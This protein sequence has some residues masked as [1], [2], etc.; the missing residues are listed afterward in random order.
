MG[1]QGNPGLGQSGHRA[2]RSNRHT[3]E[4][5]GAVHTGKSFKLMSIDVHTLEGG[6][7]V[8]TYHIEDRLGAVRQ[9]SAK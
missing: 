8:R 7:M 1:N 6:K 4:F 2:R 9:L 5:M 3:G